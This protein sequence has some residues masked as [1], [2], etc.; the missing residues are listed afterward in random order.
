MKTLLL[1]R[2][3][4]FQCAQGRDVKHRAAGTALARTEYELRAD[5]RLVAIEWRSS[6][7]DEARYAYKRQ[8]VREDPMHDLTTS[9]RQ[10]GG[11]L[12]SVRVSVDRRQ[13][14][15]I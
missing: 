14:A 6:E 2:Q 9:L 11:R 1:N 12:T 10:T 15:S 4:R 5:I 7:S 13:Y 8:S 3:E